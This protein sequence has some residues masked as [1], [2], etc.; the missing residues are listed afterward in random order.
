MINLNKLVI[1]V[2]MLL[3]LSACSE[4]EI[5]KTAVPL[6]GGTGGTGKKGWETLCIDKVEYI[7][8]SSGSYGGL[9]SVKFKPDSTVITC[10]R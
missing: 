1:S 9:L 6:K 10:D 2:F 4:S 3:L 8:K 5:A 7:Y